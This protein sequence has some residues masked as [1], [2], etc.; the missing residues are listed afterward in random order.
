MKKIRI[1]ALFAAVAASACLAFTACSSSHD[2][3]D[4]IPEQTET[5]SESMLAY[6][7]AVS[8][9]YEGSYLDFLDRYFGDDSADDE[10]EEEKDANY[11]ADIGALSVVKIQSDFQVRSNFTTRL[12]STVGSGVI[13]SIDPETYNAY[14]VTNYHVVYYLSS[15]GTE[16]IP[17]VSD[18][19]SLWLFGGET[20]SGK[21]SAEFIGGAIDYDIAVLK[22]TGNQTVQTDDGTHTNASV[23]K[24]TAAR[25]ITVADSDTVSVG[26]KVFAIG[27]ANGE[28]L[29]VTQGIISVQ[30]EYIPMSALDNPMREV[31]T[32]DMRTDAAV[33]HGN[34]GGG[35]FNAN[36]EYIGTVNARSE[37]DGVI[38]FGYAIPSN[39]SLAIARNIIDRQNAK[40]SV[41]D[42]GLETSV[43]SSRSVF[44]DGKGVV[45]SVCELGISKIS[46]VASEN[47]G[48]QVGDILLSVTY[49]GVSRK[50]THDFDLTFVYFNL[51]EGDEIS[52]E[53]LRG[54]AVQTVTFTCNAD[55]FKLV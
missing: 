3:E 36:G 51:R 31:K 19:I 28:G 2:T 34:S 45:N 43:L 37:D 23:L 53:V 47:T 27:N 39:L 52:F 25:A 44:D 17:H 13:Y 42:F 55:I 12:V 46:T 50:L 22:V 41:A 33:N 21:I 26:D 35:L 40:A 11:G 5:L 20:D 49:G 24:N 6:R 14:I 18:S 38:L 29:S 16:N 30:Y 54:G 48:L 1:A 8:A 15:V 4:P 10:P 9:G 32:L 7:E